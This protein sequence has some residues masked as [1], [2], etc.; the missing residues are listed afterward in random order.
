M[1]LPPVCVVA[2][3]I[4]FTII[5]FVLMAAASPTS[6]NG[7]ATLARVLNLLL[8]LIG[9]VGLVGLITLLP[10][11]LYLFFS[12]PKGTTPSGAPPVPPAV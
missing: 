3:P 11:G 1:I 8:G 10:I 9:L 4:L 6:G 2:A 7:L 5:N 12:T